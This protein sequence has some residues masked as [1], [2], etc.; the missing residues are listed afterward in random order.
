MTQI[1][2]ECKKKCEK[3]WKMPGDCISLHCKPHGGLR[4][5]VP[6]WGRGL[7]TILNHNICHYEQRNH[8]GQATA[9]EDQ[10]D[11]GSIP[12]SK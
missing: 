1:V 2:V 12:A 7:R 4:A 10:Q 8:Q 9:P 3:V 6:P 11:H 5:I